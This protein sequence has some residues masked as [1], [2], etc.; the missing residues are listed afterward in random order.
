MKYKTLMEAQMGAYPD[1]VALTD[2]QM[3]D[4][5]H[6]A[7]PDWLVGW[8]LELEQA[9]AQ[10]ARAAFLCRISHPYGFFYACSK[11]ADGTYR[12]VGF[13]YG[14]DESEYM[15]GFNGMNYTPKG[16]SK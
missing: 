15:S 11:R 4:L 13:R 5:L 8:S 9:Q 2:E 12:Y 1:S 3:L 16:E 7:I 10:W 14:L 6:T